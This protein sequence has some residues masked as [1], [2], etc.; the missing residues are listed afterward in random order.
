MDE[1]R[2]RGRGN[3]VRGGRRA[4]QGG[5]GAGQGGRGAGQG[6]RGAGQQGREGP[7][8]R[9]RQPRTIITDEMRATVIDHVIVH[10]MTIAEAGLRVRPNRSRFTVATIIRAFRQHNRVERMPHRG[11]RVAI[12]TAAQETPIVDMVRENNLIRLREIRDKVIDDNV[13]FEG[14]DDVS[15]AI[16]D[17]VLRCQKMQMKQVYRV[18]FERNS[19]R[20]KDL[21][22]E[23]VQV[24]IHPCSQYS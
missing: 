5:R 1:G 17:R 13:N 22:Y 21:R 15:L 23:Y 2:V 10:G 19:A 6:G 4:G 20:H 12:F 18:P 7:G 9:A 3:R 14:I 24:S 16:I 11:G 8:G